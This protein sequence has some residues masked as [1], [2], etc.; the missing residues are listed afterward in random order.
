MA[1]RT[2]FFDLGDTLV[3]SSR[4]W[5]AGAKALLASLK[6]KGFQIGII[7]NTGD[8]TTRAE[9]LNLLP[10]DFD[11]SL[12][13]PALVLFSSEFGVA[14]PKP[15]IFE[16]AVRR[17]N[18]PA[19]ECLY[20]SENIVETLVAQSVGMLALRVQPPPASDLSTLEL[21]IADFHNHAASTSVASVTAR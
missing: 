13:E 18:I 8:L 14:K 15:S 20:C 1:I 17:A 19:G 16:E 3:T 10:S 9:I 2:L 6:S 21:R 4:T 11:L 5:L 12:F 7:S